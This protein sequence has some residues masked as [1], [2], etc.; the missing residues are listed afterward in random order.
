MLQL[1]IDRAGGRQKEAVARVEYR[2]PL[3]RQQQREREG[4][5]RGLRWRI[6]VEL[7]WLWLE[8]EMRSAGWV[9]TLCIVSF[10]GLRL[11]AAQTHCLPGGPHKLASARAADWPYVHQVLVEVGLGRLGHTS[12]ARFQIR[13][14]ASQISFLRRKLVTAE[15]LLNR[16]NWRAHKLA[17]PFSDAF[18]R[19]R[20]HLK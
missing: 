13:G 16:H 12:W 6:A 4:E 20:L 3:Y 5:R 17:P 11:P 10:G 1:K 2:V 7:S 9:T 8:I 15:P 14:L 19:P 18:A